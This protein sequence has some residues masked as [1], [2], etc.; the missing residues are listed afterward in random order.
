MER[1]G[2]VPFWHLPT[3]YFADLREVLG[4]RLYLCVV[5]LGD[6]LATASLL[7]ETDGIVEYHLSGTVDAFLW[8]SPSKLLIDYARSWARDRGNR[9][10]HLTGSLG[11]GDSLSQF[12]AGFSRD[13]HPVASWRLITDGGRYAAL[14]R[15]W[16]RRHGQPADPPDGFFP[17]YRKPGRILSGAA[18]PRR[19]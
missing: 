3:G 4:E 12:K 19:R 17:A 18:D 1:V 11:P 13:Q 14:T 7:T 2:A 9:T 16:E 8:A 15:A 5:E 10:F 6:E